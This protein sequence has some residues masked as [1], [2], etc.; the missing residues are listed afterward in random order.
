M[1]GG[2]LHVRAGRLYSRL[3][4]LTA[5]SGAPLAVLLYARAGD[6]PT[7]RAAMFLGYLLLIL[8]MPVFHGIRVARRRAAGAIASPLHTLICVAAAAAGLLLGIAAIL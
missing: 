5:L 2:P 8:V 1:K 3:I 6:A 4:Y 7:R